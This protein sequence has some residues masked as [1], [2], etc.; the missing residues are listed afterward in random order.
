MKRVNTS[1]EVVPTNVAPLGLAE[2]Q[3]M[4]EERGR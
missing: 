4:E 2:T 3:M 1:E